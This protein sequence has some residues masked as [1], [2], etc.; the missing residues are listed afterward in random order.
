MMRVY[1]HTY[2]HMYIHTYIRAPP[3]TH[4]VSRGQKFL[5]C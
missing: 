4:E 1:I 3:L 5:A 2:I